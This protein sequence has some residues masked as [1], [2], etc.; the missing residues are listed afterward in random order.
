MK[1]RKIL[2]ASCAIFPTVI[3]AKAELNLWQQGFVGCTVTSSPYANQVLFKDASKVR[4]LM[5]IA[6]MNAWAVPTPDGGQQVALT[7]PDGLTIYGRI[8]G[9]SGED[10][11]AALL[12]TVPTVKPE[13]SSFDPAPVAATSSQPASALQAASN[14]TESPNLPAQPN[15]TVA[16]SPP[17]AG[18]TSQARPATTQQSVQQAAQSPAAPQQ[19]A[20]VGSQNVTDVPKA[21]SVEQLIQQAQDFS[22]WFPVNTPKPGSPLVYVFVDP[23]CPH[24]AWSFDHLMPRIKDNSIDLRVILTPILSAEAFDI[25]ASIM[26]QDDIATTLLE[27]TR[28]VIGS[29]KPAPKV[30]PKQF[31][32]RVTEGLRRNVLWMRSNGAPGVPFYLYRSKHGAQF[33]FGSL[34]DAQLASALPDAQP[35][36]TAASTGAGAQ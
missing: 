26:H 21:S 2:L 33:A 25:A 18:S 14:T 1:A 3:P 10:I 9:P 28:S 13:G 31:D 5:Q 17:P 23:T 4:P 20:S 12:A 15:A 11:S 32:P 22:M 24:C 16:I 30:D 34:T 35:A 36:N 7:T 29:G 8:V 19:L 6:G 27:Q